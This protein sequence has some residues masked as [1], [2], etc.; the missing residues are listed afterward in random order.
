MQ[1]FQMAQPDTLDEA[2]QLLV[3]HGSDAR[4]YAGGQDLLYRF[5]RR[6]ASNP[7]YLVNLK[8]VAELRGFE[9]TA[10]GGLRIRPLTTLGELERSPA[11]RDRFPLLH[12]AISEIASPQIRNL[13][14]VGGNLL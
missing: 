12:G 4:V 9:L 6:I 10:D 14:T 13:G 2:I 8:N 7:L 3:A 1:L 11:L 5:K